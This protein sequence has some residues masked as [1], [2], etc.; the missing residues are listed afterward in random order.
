MQ[1]P[2][3]GNP[4]PM[5]IGCNQRG[6]ALVA[7]IRNEH[8]VAAREPTANQFERKQD[9]LALALSG[10]TISHRTTA[11]VCSKMLVPRS[12]RPPA[13]IKLRMA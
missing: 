9:M 13:R 8:D 4:G 2:Q 12:V 10:W 3:M 7:V 11:V 5:Q 1:A 6:N